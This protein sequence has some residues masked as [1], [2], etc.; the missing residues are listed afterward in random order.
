MPANQAQCLGLAKTQR[1]MDLV[2]DHWNI[3]VALLGACRFVLDKFAVRSGGAPAPD[4]DH[5]FG[6]VE[7]GLDRLA[8]RSSAANLRVPPDRKAASLER[9]D[10]RLHAPPILSLVRDEYVRHRAAPARGF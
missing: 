1:Q 7:L 3:D 8:P 5:A 4:D 10:K 9:I 6:G 2:D